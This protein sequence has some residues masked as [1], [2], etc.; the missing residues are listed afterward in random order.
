MIKINKEVLLTILGVLLPFVSQAQ[1]IADDMNGLHSVLEKLYDEMM[2]LCSNLLGVGQGLAGFAAIWYIA[3]RVWRHIASAEPIDFYPLF[4]PFVIGFCIMIFP[5][6]LYMINGVM[7]PTVTATAAMV[8][9]SNKAIERLLKEKE[10][11]LKNSDPW[12]MYVG[13]TGGGDQDKWYRYTHD[14]EDP[15]KEGMLNGIGNDI[16]FAMSKASYNFRHSVKELMS[17]VLRVLFEAASLCIDTLRTFQLVVLSILGPLVFGISVFDGFQHTLTVWLARYIN[18]YLWLPVAN[19]FGGIIGKIQENMIKIDI[20]QVNEKGDTFFSSSDAAYLVFMIIGIV[21]YF[22]VPSVANYIV[23]AGGGGAL[24]Q[25]VTSIFSN[26]TS[27]AMGT[28][29][30]GAGMTADAM[31]NAV[32]RISQSMSSSGNSSSYFKDKEGYMGNKLKGN[33]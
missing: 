4:R 27:S 15:K 30:Q 18:I 9:G 10:E 20:G 19:I 14:D 29:S 28:V 24:G 25:K 31:G 23:H 12:K 17:E 6:V 16:K 11:A 7:K 32:G 26:A 13:S 1:G 21:G 33:S 5:S 22:T 3:S 8:E 2:P